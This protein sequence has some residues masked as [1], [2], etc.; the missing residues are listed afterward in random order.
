MRPVEEFQGICVE[1]TEASIDKNARIAIYRANDNPDVK[2]LE[3]T[4]NEAFYLANAMISLARS[5]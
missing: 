2:R 5:M 4:K 1:V 3:L